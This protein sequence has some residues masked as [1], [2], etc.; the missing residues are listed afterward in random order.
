M[1][2]GNAQMG[3]HVA[4]MCVAEPERSAFF[5]PE[6]MRRLKSLCDLRIVDREGLDE[7]DR[8]AA[9]MK[10]AS[11]AITSWGFPAWT[12]DRLAAA[13]RLGLVMHSGASV[14]FFATAALWESDVRVSQAGDAMAPAVAEISLAF[15]LAL[16]RRLPSLDHALRTGAS[17]DRARGARR[18][19]E[20]SGSTIGVVGASRTGRSYIEKC[21]A[22]G[23]DIRIYD[24]YLDAGDPLAAFAVPFEDLLAMSDAVALH[25]PSTPETAGM[26]GREQLALMRDDGLLVNTARS[27]LVDMNAL[28]DEAASG[29][30]DVALDVYDIEP[31]PQQDRWRALPNV[32][33]TPH[34]GGATAQSRRRAGEIVLS[35]IDRFLSGKPLVHEVDPVG[36][37]T[38]G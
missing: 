1:H 30:I 12:A 27:A 17:W 5:P 6:M 18:G 38:R 23:A 15:T 24:P 37:E 32:L 26:L 10:D 8:F 22:L 21:R 36:L 35:E 11:V 3:S 13:P 20:I 4:V 29:R 14:R 16:L 28:Y 34:L 19:S 7:H 33:L 9:V 2:Q 31:L 25:A